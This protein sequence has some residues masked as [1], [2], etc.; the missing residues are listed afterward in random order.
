VP[1]AARA[2]DLTAHGTPLTGGGSTDVLIGG[3]P[4]WRASSDFHAC[5]VTTGTV[6]HVGGV[7]ATGSST[8]LINGAPAARQGDAIVENGPPNAIVLGESTVL[9]GGGS[10]STGPEWAA[11]V[12]KKLA[13]YVDEYNRAVTSADV[14]RVGGQLQNEVVNLAVTTEGGEAVFSFR[15]DGQNRIHGL[16][17]GPDE[18]ATVRMETDR[19]TVDRIADADEPVPAFRRA[20]VEDVEIHGIG[21]GNAAKWWLLDGVKGLLTAVG[22]R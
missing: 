19:S 18:D 3:Q 8:V 6:P 14:G 4:A 5:P 21:L 17:R 15:T 2:G 7:V 1:P 20:V 10:T 22:G 13:S 16:S 9:I 12:Y 11:S